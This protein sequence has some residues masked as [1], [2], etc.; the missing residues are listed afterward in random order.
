LRLFVIMWVLLLPDMQGQ[1]TVYDGTINECL[2]EALDFNE[3]ETYAY[4][5]CYVD[6]QPPEV[7]P[8]LEKR[9]W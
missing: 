8:P 2:E 6:V 1:R 7:V 5:G 9:S 3:V 4:A